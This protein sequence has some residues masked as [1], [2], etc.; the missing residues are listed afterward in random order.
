VRPHL[1]TAIVVVGCAVSG[2]SGCD[3]TEDTFAVTLLNDTQEMLVA[4]QCGNG[5]DAAPTEKDKLNPG[6]S[7][8][9]NTS[10]SHVDNWW[11]ITSRRGR[12]LGCLNLLYDHKEAHAVVRLSDLTACPKH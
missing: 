4:D 9:V 5:C 7:V 12:A 6:D 8:A 3:P 10:S 1:V 2:F 11:R